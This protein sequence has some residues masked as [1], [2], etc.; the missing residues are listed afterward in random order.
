ME[1]KLVSKRAEFME[2]DKP[3]PCCIDPNSS[4]KAKALSFVTRL[5]IGRNTP[6]I[7]NKISDWL[8]HRQRAQ[9]LCCN[10]NPGISMKRDLVIKSDAPP[11]H[12]LCWFWVTLRPC[13]CH[14]VIFLESL[15]FFSFPVTSV[16]LH[17]N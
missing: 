7:C 11:L 17:S 14:H 10:R 13:S 12:A 9:D 15:L 8:K 2:Q 4:Y 5:L 1:R 3:F 16:I 6:V